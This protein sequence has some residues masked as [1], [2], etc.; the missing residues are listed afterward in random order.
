[1]KKI[2]LLIFC[3][4]ITSGC[5]ASSNNKIT[6]SS[7]N[8]EIHEL[9]YEELKTKLASKDN[10]VLYIGR[11]DCGDCIEF[12]PILK[13][14]LDRNHGIDIYYLNIKTFRDNSRKVD[15]TKEEK[16]FFANLYTELDFD[17]TPTLQHINSGE[18][19]SKYT[20]LDKEYYEL[21]ADSEKARDTKQAF[22]D[23]FYK[24]VEEQ[25]K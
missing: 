15:A 20:Y 22:I 8:S 23:D 12:E 17:W 2:I 19:L 21:K 25:F 10:F 3:I 4:L 7:K 18:I 16:D 24:W 13:E 14:Y 1:M 11:P 6:L 5:A 9:S